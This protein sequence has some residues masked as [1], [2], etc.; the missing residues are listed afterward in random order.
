MKTVDGLVE[1]EG[2]EGMK[3]VEGVADNEEVVGVEEVEEEEGTG[4]A[5]WSDSVEESAAENLFDE[6]GNDWG[7]G[8]QHQICNR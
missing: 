3:G 2:V 7:R 1:L 5:A 6:R 8:V 4:A